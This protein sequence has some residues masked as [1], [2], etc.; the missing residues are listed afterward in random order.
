RDLRRVEVE[1]DGPSAPDV[2]VRRLA[3]IVAE[4]LEAAMLELDAGRACAFRD[5]VD[6]DLGERARGGT[7][8]HPDL[9]GEDQ[10]TARLPVEH[11]ADGE[12][13][14]VLAGGV[15]APA[16]PG[17]EE[18]PLQGGAAVALLPRPPAVDAVGEDRE[19]V[20]RVRPHDEALAHR[21]DGDGQGH[22]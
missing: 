10:A 18:H 1:D 13:G 5:E 20:R 15:P 16:L 8:R 6:L 9:P 22:G 12:L 2:A 19:G 14:A 17:L 11:G 4:T 21:G 7:P 3:E